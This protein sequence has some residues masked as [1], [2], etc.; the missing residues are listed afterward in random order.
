[1]I[2]KKNTYFD[3]EK[4]HRHSDGW[5]K[6]YTSWFYAEDDCNIEVRE[7]LYEREIHD[8][9]EALRKA[10]MKSFV[11][12]DHRTNLI[13]QLHAFVEEGCTLNGVCTMYKNSSFCTKYKVNG[14][15]INLN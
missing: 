1:M 3:S 6:A 13:E 9:V 15:R 10:G 14:I 2:R 7:L 12:T 11:I 5:N 8:F 4:E